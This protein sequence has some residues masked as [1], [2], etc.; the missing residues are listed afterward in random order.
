MSDTE[1][2]LEHGRFNPRLKTYLFINFALILVMTIFGVVL[3]ILTPLWWYLLDRYYR[4]L[5]CNL[6]EK[7]LKV[8]VG[9]IVKRE[10]NIPLEQITDMG[11]VEGPLMR[12]VGVKRVTV[13]TAGQSAAGALV[14]LIGL[15]DIESFR[16]AV[17][18]QRDQL[19]QNSMPT[20]QNAATDGSDPVE[21]P[22][23]LQPEILATLQRIEKLL[24]QQR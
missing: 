19:R 4:S 2:I 8:R 9:V 13:E 5:E 10:K 3:L 12:M 21:Q 24:E 15:E 6:T 20:Y 14:R 18:K 11:I 16:D 17:L 7:F 22:G 23:D 1:H